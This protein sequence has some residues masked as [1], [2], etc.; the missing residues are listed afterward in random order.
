MTPFVLH[1]QLNG[2]KCMEVACSDPDEAAGA[3]AMM[4]NTG[5]KNHKSATFRLPKELLE[6]LA[7]AADMQ[8]RSQTTLVRRAL[9]M[10]LEKQK[11]MAG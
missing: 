7:A 10:Y 3:I 5:E 2:L 6:K 9:E 4:K 1:R 11:G 8:E